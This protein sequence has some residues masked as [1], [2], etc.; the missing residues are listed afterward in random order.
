MFNGFISGT[1]HKFDLLKYDTNTNTNDLLD[2][3]ISLGL[4]PTITYPTS[5][6]HSSATLI[7]NI[8]IK[9]FNYLSHHAG[10]LNY[11][12]SDHLH[13]ITFLGKIWQKD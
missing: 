12:I 10:V 3:L 7:D 4:L 11:Q 8:Y 5:I 2:G 1:D 6:T 9:G 13:I